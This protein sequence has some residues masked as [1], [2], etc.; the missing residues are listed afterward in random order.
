MPVERDGDCLH[1]REITHQVGPRDVD[2]AG[3]EA[4]LQV[5]LQAQRQEAGHD[6]ADAGVVP[7]VVEGSDLQCRLLLAKGALHPPQALVGPRDLLRGQLGVGAQDEFPVEPR[8][9]LHGSAVD[10]HTAA[11]DGDEA[12]EA[13]VPDDGLGPVRERCLELG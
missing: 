6:V 5:D 7:V 4:S 12:G 8:V 1:P 11:L 13:L 9:G 10:G 3:L 2:P